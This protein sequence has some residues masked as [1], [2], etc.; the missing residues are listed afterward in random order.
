MK[1]VTHKEFV[2]VIKV[3]KLI[4][5]YIHRMG[6]KAGA[7]YQ[8]NYFLGDCPEPFGYRKYLK[9]TGNGSL[10]YYLK[11][12]LVSNIVSIPD[13]SA[14]CFSTMSAISHSGVSQ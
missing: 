5:M 4:G 8:L 9:P 7:M 11:S 10:Q 13:K 1:E 12:S 2:G 14:P 6:S 3:Y